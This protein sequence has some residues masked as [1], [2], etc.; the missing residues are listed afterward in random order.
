MSKAFPIK[1]FPEYYI[2]DAGDVFSR[3]VRKSTNRNGRIKKMSLVTDRN[4][5]LRVW[6]RT[7]TRNSRLIHRL[8]AEAFIPNP[9]NKPEVNHINGI[10]TD[11][12]VENL[13]WVTRSENTLHACRVLKAR[14]NK[15]IRKPVQQLING[16]I[17]AEFDSVADA[18]RKTGINVEGITNCCKNKKGYNFAG[19]Y[20]WRYK[21]D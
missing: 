18:H 11:N 2:T 15:P 7:P 14:K 19:G 5:Y 10:K 17:F 12:R 21:N 8:V 16:T 1:D 6:F 9:D 13:E 20:Q 4:G 3:V